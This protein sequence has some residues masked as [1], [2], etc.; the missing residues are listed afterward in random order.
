MRVDVARLAEEIERRREQQVRDELIVQ[1]VDYVRETRL[2]VA[3]VLS[4]EVLAQCD[5]VELTDFADLRNQVILAD[6][7]RLQHAHG[8]LDPYE[9]LRTIAKDEVVVYLAEA[10]A[11]CA[12]FVG[13]RCVDE[14]K[15]HL[16]RLA[17]RRAAQ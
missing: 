5:D 1:L 10:I 11:R 17:E 9:L 8:K 14:Y 12:P 15:A 2:L 6:L 13:P 7:R 3:M 16:R 4:A